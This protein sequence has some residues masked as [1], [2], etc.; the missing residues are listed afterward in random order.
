MWVNTPATG[1]GE[2]CVPDEIW[3]AVDR[4]IS[5]QLV[6]ADDALDAAIAASRAAG[7]PD[8]QVTPNQGMLLHLLALVHHARRILEVGTLGAYS[9]IWL[10]RALP[11][12][13]MLLTVEAE[14]RHAAV[15]RRNLAAA[16]VADLRLTH[17]WG[18]EKKLP[19]HSPACRQAKGARGSVSATS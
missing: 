18:W 14:P 8:I 12:D 19:Y 13:G 11:S 1:K 7:L 3:A 17:N 2:P 9:A 5:D 16:G 15:A 4:F 6:P 10:A